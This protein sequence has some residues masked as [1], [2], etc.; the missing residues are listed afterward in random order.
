[1]NFIIENFCKFNNISENYKPTNNKINVVST[2]LFKM[3]DGY[4]DFSKYINGLDNIINNLL[5]RLSNN[6][7]LLLFV[8]NSILQEPE[9]IN[10]ITKYSREKIIII[11]Y[12]C[13]RFIKNNKHIELFG[14]LIRFLPFFKFENNFTSHVICV[15]A[16]TNSKDD[17]DKLVESYNIFLKTNVEYLYRSNLFYNLFSTWATDEPILAGKQIC[18]RKFPLHIL[19]NFLNCV[20]D[21]S[22]AYYD[23]IKEKINFKT[24]ELFPYGIDEYFLDYILLEYL[25]NN[26]VPYGVILSYNL[27]TPLMYLYRTVYNKELSKEKK[28]YIK[29]HI[30]DIIEIKNG[31]T[32]HKL[33]EY[34]EIFDKTLYKD[35]KFLRKKKIKYPKHVNTN[36]KN[37]ALK[38]YNKIQSLLD[39]KDYSIFDESTLKK[40]LAY[41]DY[42]YHSKVNIY[43]GKRLVRIMILDKIYL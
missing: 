14:T 36:A 4:K 10:K 40:I 3:T 25:K 38:Y 24:Y 35:I 18:K 19:T 29:K 32:R 26:N 2:S 7:K 30:K 5:E 8:D 11:N 23:N 42:M 41:K 34:M 12:E 33:Q 15:D 28:R 43:K 17:I 27:V 13:P 9:I 37:I 39:T 20:L 6:F 16:D 31:N 22:C 21:K 1:M